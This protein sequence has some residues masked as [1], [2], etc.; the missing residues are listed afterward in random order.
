MKILTILIKGAANVLKKQD[1]HK[2]SDVELEIHV[3]EQEADMCRLL[4]EEKVFVTGVM[5]TTT[6]DCLN[7]YMEVK[8]GTEP[9]NISYGTDKTSALITFED[10]VGRCLL[11]FSPVYKFG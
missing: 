10:K 5:N 9:T 11:S 6:E 7:D 8:S 3:I 1:V 4:E 2:V